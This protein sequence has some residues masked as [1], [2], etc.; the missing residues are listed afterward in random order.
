MQ[1]CRDAIAPNDDRRAR[2]ST[3][4]LSEF[5]QDLG[6][7]RERITM[8]VKAMRLLVPSIKTE[9]LLASFVLPKVVERVEAVKLLEERIR[10]C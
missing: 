10:E 2:R 6:T 1:L 4:E 9:N 3:G 8:M 7:L 5:F